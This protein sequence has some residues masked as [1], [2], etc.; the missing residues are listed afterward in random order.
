[1]N[2]LEEGARGFGVELTRE[3]LDRFEAYYRHLVEWNAR[4]NLTAI[5]GYGEVRVLHFLDSLSVVCALPRERLADRKLIDV[6]AGAGFPGVP[7]AIAFPQLRV[8][9]LEATGKKVAFLDDLARALALDNVTTLQG[10]AEDLGQREEHR[11]QYDL[12]VARAVAGMRTLV[13]YALP[14]VRV[15]GTVIASKGADAAEETEAAAKA[16]Q[17][18][19]GE[20]R[21]VVPVVLPTLDEPRGLAV[22][23]KVAPTPARYPRRAGVPSKRPLPS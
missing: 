18:L 21:Q 6:G 3:Q 12:A 14:F 7:L 13:E 8:T 2:L 19:G 1:M 10:R 17:Q 11:E 9:L 22:I 15:N 23:E 20:L 16:I 4:I 5:T